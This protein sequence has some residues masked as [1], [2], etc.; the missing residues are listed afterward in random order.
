MYGFSLSFS[1]LKFF[2]VGYCS[3]LT[4]HTTENRIDKYEAEEHFSIFLSHPT[5]DHVV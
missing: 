5:L 2:E 3:E 4:E 1:P